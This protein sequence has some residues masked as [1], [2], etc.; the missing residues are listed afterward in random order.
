[1]R[2]GLNPK[3]KKS[4]I[5]ILIFLFLPIVL[6]II[7]YKLNILKIQNVEIK[8][9]G[10]DCINGNNLNEKNML[11]GRNF[12]TFS[13]D[14]INSKIKKNNICIKDVIY[15]R[16]FPKTVEITLVGRK[17]IIKLLEVRDFEASA[18]ALIEN[19]AT[20]SADESDAFIADDEGIVFSKDT[21][22]D[23][24]K[25]YII[26]QSLKIGTEFENNSLKKMIDILKKLPGFGVD[27]RSSY[28]YTGLLIIN[29][30]PK[31]IFKLDQDIDIQIASLQLILQK[32]K[33]D[34]ERLE[35]IDLR[36]DKP[37]IKY[38]P[39]KKNG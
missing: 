29:T 8:N 14:E 1:M 23:L 3:R 19:T 11:L 30:S 5:K 10:A 2:Q 22:L 17:P 33:M 13:T 7:F 34:S 18:S 38:F 20:P 9:E 6:I 4:R 31:I 27:N 21:D 12:F 35:F 32:A 36:F 37:I 15:S 25:V 39:K 24:P 26:G 28:F 16:N